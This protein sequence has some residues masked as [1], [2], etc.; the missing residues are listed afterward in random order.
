MGLCFPALLR[1]HGRLVHGATL[2]MLELIPIDPEGLRLCTHIARA[3]ICRVLCVGLL[4]G[5]PLGS[6]R[7]PAQKRHTTTKPCLQV[8]RVLM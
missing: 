6:P 2:A 1:I 7:R 5:K 4:P 3:L 8:L